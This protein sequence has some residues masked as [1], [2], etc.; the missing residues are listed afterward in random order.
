MIQLL[1]YP[2]NSQTP[3]RGP[4]AGVK[5]TTDKSLH[6]GD[7]CNTLNISFSNH[8]GTHVDA[9]FHF[10]ERGAKLTDFAPETWWVKN[11]RCIQLSECPPSASMMGCEILD[12]LEPD[13][14]VEAL[15]LRTGYWKLRAEEIYRNFSPGFSPELAD[16]I[17]ALF[18]QVRFF[19]FDI[20]SLSSFQHRGIGKAAHLAFLDRPAPIMLIEDMDLSQVESNRLQNVLISP[21]FVDA[22]DGSPCT[23]WAGL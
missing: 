19:G 6:G 7:S 8:L 21:L 15:F 18:P 11:A 17:Y 12:G 10:C 9:P 22:A 1:S 3:V 2:L 5:V 14:A 20:I 23:V 16:A 4:G 13:D